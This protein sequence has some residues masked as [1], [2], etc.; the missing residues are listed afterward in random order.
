MAHI[1]SGNTPTLGFTLRMP[2]LFET[3]VRTALRHFSGFT[4]REF[5]DVWSNVLTL[6][7][8]ET[9]K[10]QPDLGVCTDGVWRFVGDVKYKRDT[11]TGKNADLYQLLAYATATNLPSATLLYANGP[12]NFRKQHVR[13]AGVELRIRHLDLAQSPPQV[14]N[15]LSRIASEELYRV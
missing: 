7:E 8:A 4:R 10:L 3:F 6:D 13:H 1:S 5:P 12:H 11:G 14:L 9:V 15:Q 2:G